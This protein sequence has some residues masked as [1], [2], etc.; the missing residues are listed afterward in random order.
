MVQ[1]FFHP[2][3]GNGVKI[4]ERNGGHEYFIKFDLGFSWWIP[5]KELTRA[6]L[7][8]NVVKSSNSPEINKKIRQDEKFLDMLVLEALRIGVSP[9]EQI[10]EFTH[11]RKKECDQVKKFLQDEEK[12]SMFIVGEYGSGKSHL[13]EIV[14]SLSLKNEWAVSSLEIDQ[15]E[16]PLYMP[17]RIYREIIS[18]FKY[19]KDGQ[20]YDFKDFIRDIARAPDSSQK[21]K[22]LSHK[23]LGEAIRMVKRSGDESIE[24]DTIWDWIRGDSLDIPMRAKMYDQQTSGNIYANII[25][26][27]GWAAKN[28]LDL[29][30]FLIIFDEAENKESD[31]FNKRQ[32]FMSYNFFKGLVLMSQND[33]RL[34]QEAEERFE[35]GPN[36]AWIGSMTKLQYSGQSGYQYSFLWKDRSYTKLIFSNVLFDDDDLVE[37]NDGSELIEL[38]NLNDSDLMQIYLNVLE[39]YKRA[40]D[41]SPERELKDRIFI[42]LP[43]TITRKFVKGTVEALDLLRHFPDRDT[44]ELLNLEY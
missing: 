23:Y 41:F 10:E 13:I 4:L 39:I 25:S 38:D 31:C 1:H 8:H 29:N 42:K 9:K 15:F 37:I 18:T 30:G 40:Y 2:R 22:I 35:D 44:E 21:R 19:K 28:I 32:Q 11:G 27:I 6:D 34:V 20:I 33:D 36:H 26:A 3:Y 16:A 43:R 17:K 24:D 12:G 5:R 7:S 14:N